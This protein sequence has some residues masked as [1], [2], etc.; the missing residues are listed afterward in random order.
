MSKPRLRSHRLAGRAGLPTVPSPPAGPAPVA[1]TLL[2]RRD[3]LAAGL[4]SAAVLVAFQALGSRFARADGASKV[5]GVAGV[6][7]YGVA[8]GDPLPDRVIIWTRV[9]PTPEAIPGSGLGEPTRGTWEVARDAAFTQ[10]VAG[11]RFLTAPERDHTVKIDVAGLNPSTDYFYRFYALGQYS[12]VGRMR[13]SPALGAVVS[14]VR[15]G[16]VSCSNYEGG[17]FSSYRF[18]AQ[19]DDLD[20]ILH[21]GDYI[22]EYETGGYGPGPAIGRVNEPANE[23]I[24]LSD[25]RRRHA[26][27][28]TDPDLRALHARHA[29]ITT[30]DDHEVANDNWAGGAQNHTDPTKGS[31]GEGPYLE[32]RAHAYQAYF[33]WM[34]LRLPDPIGNPT[35]IYRKFTFGN[36]VDLLMLDLRQYRAKQATGPADPALGDPMRRMISA[37]EATWFK[38]NLSGSQ[39]TWKMVGNSVIISP[40]LIPP[41]D[42]L[43]PELRAL[44]MA[45]LGTVPTVAIPYNVDQWDGYA[46][47]RNELLDYLRT[48]AIRNVVFLTGDIHS[49]WAI[50]VPQR[51]SSYAGPA[52]AV[53]TEFVC[54]S[55]TSDNFNEIL[56]NQPERNPTSLAVEQI[57]RIGNP[58]LQTVQLDSHGYCVV[59]V[60]PQRAQC[61]WFYLANRADPNTTQQF[62]TAWQVA[63]GT[64]S[65]VPANGP[66]GPRV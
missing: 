49:T 20:F 54:T 53:A 4:K 66:L 12:S 27:Y 65:V 39:A 56:G 42:A 5:D 44:V 14:S 31:P 43:T 23:I 38:A 15:F 58:W 55:V 33:E 11:G 57:F 30:W 50:N 18:L 40:V 10:R 2:G 35:R 45:L 46:P 13:T 26:L 41:G 6:F 22:Y 47:A 25:Y 61:D 60:T 7:T 34:P 48:E 1:S 8:S 24:S 62:A 16:F 9:N 29:F 19:R 17:F 64:N 21:D 36:L 51:P 52:D 37:D 28:K 32:R 59:D 3:F 63:A